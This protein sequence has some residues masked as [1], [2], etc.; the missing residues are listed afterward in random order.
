MTQRQRVL[1]MLKDAG[2]KGVSSKTFIESYLPRAPA[3]IQE[4]KDE[5]V[6]ITTEREGK[7]VRYFVGVGTGHNAEPG[8]QQSS[9]AAAARGDKA[10]VYP[11]EAGVLPPQGS[12]GEGR[13]ARAAFARSVPSMFDADVS[14]EDAA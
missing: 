4:L 12:A 8:A 11:G 1:W 6:P 3:R 9:S 2:A 13:R 14:W 7:Y 10:S 5:G